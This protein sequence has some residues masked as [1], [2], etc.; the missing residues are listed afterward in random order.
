MG[1]DVQVDAAI[2]T[3]YTARKAAK[4]AKSSAKKKAAAT[5]AYEKDMAAA[6]ARAL[7]EQAANEAKRIKAAG[8][9][10]QKVQRAAAAKAGLALGEGTAEDIITETGILVEKDI[11]SVTSEAKSKGELLKKGAAGRAP[12]LMQKAKDIGA[13]AEA[14]AK[15]T[16]VKAGFSRF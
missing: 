11:Q 8:E 13:Q 2:Y 14:N 5:A 12:L 1:A 15:A 7:E 10:R 9:H 3:A 6:Q 16:A 4:E